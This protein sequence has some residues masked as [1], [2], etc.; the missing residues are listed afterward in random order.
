[1]ETT[2]VYR[3]LHRDNGKEKWKLLHYN[4]VYIGVISDRLVVEAFC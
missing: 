1:M 4:R 3:G 2:I